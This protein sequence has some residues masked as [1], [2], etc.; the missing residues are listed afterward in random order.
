LISICLHPLNSKKSIRN[1]VG[2]LEKPYSGSFILQ[3]AESRLQK[4]V[5]LIFFFFC[6]Q[7]SAFGLLPSVTGLGK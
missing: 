4:A 6:L 2:L 1:R 7:P 3:M 5:K